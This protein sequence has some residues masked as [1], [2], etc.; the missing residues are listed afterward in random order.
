MALSLLLSLNSAGT[1][2]HVKLEID[3]AY[4]IRRTILPTSDTG[5]RLPLLSTW[6]ATVLGVS[7]MLVSMTA[8]VIDAKH[9]EKPGERQNGIREVVFRWKCFSCLSQLIRCHDFKHLD[10]K[11]I[12]FHEY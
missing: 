8:E 11:Q 12:V 3:A 9:S 10:R 2:S 7:V 6:F 4:D 1:R 5:M